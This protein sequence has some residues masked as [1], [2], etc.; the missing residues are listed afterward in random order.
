M[1]NG[2]GPTVPSKPPRRSFEASERERAA[3]EMRRN[4][5]IAWDEVRTAQLRRGVLCGRLGMKLLDGTERKLLW[6]TR[7]PAYEP[8]ATALASNLGPRLE[9]E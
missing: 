5:F 1:E 2:L 4:L 8:L 3:R 6:L 7:D 9:I